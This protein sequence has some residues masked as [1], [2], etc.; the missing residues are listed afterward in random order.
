[1]KKTRIIALLLVV[2]MV[3]ISILSGCTKTPTEKK[4]D[5]EPTASA[6]DTKSTGST[7]KIGIAIYSMGADSCVAMVEDCRDAAKKL[8]WEI[9]LMDANGDPSTQADQ[10]ASLVSQGVDAI[11]LNPTDTTS[12]IPSIKNAIDAGI[13][14]M[15]GG[16][17]MDQEAMDLILFFAGVDDYGLAYSGCE[18][19]AE[20]YNGKKAQVALITGPAGTDPTNKTIKA[21]EDAVAE[22]DIEYVGSFDGEWDSAKAMSITE[23]LMVKYPNLSVIYCQDHVLSLGAA[24]AI[25]D[26]G[27]GEKIAVVGASGMKDYLKYI[28]DGTIKCFSYVLLYECGGFALETLNEYWTNGV[29]P[30]KKYYGVPIAVTSENVADAYNAS[31]DF[32][33]V[34]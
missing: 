20:N 13:P 10:M 12:L 29:K 22:T 19:I 32:E 30:A 14:V 18:W 7:K 1:M 9:V 6:D 33:P 15:A 31:F 27:M 4:L 3:G 8:G 5:S 34:E 23:D 26:A 11:L 24:S 2:L 28:E 21:F 17:E 16:M 25:Q